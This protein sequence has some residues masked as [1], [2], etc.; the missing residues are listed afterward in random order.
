M[1]APDSSAETP[2]HVETGC[3]A[4]EPKAFFS[5]NVCKLFAHPIDKASGNK[6]LAMSVA[7]L[8]E[9]EKLCRNEEMLLGLSNVLT[10]PFD[11]ILTTCRALVATSSPTPCYL[12]AK[13]SDV[14]MVF[15]PER[16]SPEAAACD[17]RDNFRDIHSACQK[18]AHWRTCLQ[19]YLIMGVED[20]AHAVVHQEALDTMQGAQEV[21]ASM[22]KGVI[23]TCRRLMKKLRVGCCTLI[24]KELI[25][26]V[27]KADLDCSENCQVV[28]DITMLVDPSKLNKDLVARATSASEKLRNNEQQ[29]SLQNFLEVLNDPRKATLEGMRDGQACSTINK[30]IGQTVADNVQSLA[31][32]FVGL[33]LGNIV[34]VVL[35]A[36]KAASSWEGDMG[37][38]NEVVTALAAVVGVDFASTA[39]EPFKFCK[40][41][42]E[43]LMSFK[44]AMCGLEQACGDDEL[45][46]SV[47]VVLS[48]R[49]ALQSFVSAMTKTEGAA[50][51]EGNLHV[52]ALED[53]SKTCMANALQLIT[54]KVAACRTQAIKE[55]RRP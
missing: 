43:L 39:L 4:V 19:S 46:Q 10:G 47:I 24:F 38:A 55:L 37:E 16:L 48:R 52:V 20:E 5:N 6:P 54:E 29:L 17:G 35:A 53:H 18:N 30:T 2:A 27:M 32:L 7:I 12:G 50:G 3:G 1:I 8:K 42:A 31:T 33:I 23:G 25:D 26:W 44:T 34:S 40:S 15:F 9:Y 11:R 45:K 49:D 28:M 41:L 21:S 51:E 14:E 22:V 13:F 36:E